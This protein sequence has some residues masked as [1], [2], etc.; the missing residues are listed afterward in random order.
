MIEN[1][2]TSSEVSKV[3]PFTKK[4]SKAVTVKELCQDEDIATLF[5]I[6]CQ[7]D[8]RKQAIAAIEKRLFDIK[9][10]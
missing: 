1:V 9:S 6:V 8:L 4:S 5:K 2:S 7:H 10:M 3:V